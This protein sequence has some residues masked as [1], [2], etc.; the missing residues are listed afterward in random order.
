MR[1]SDVFRDMGINLPE[2]EFDIVGITHDSRQVQPGDLFVALEGE[3]F[4]G[5]KFAVDARARGAVGIVGRGERPDELDGP[6]ISVDDPRQ[7]FGLLASRI[8]EHPDRQ[9]T[10]VGVTGT[11]G[12][13]TI[14]NVLRS[15]L[16]AAG[17]P[18]ASL[19]TLGYRFGDDHVPG[20][21]TTPEAG[22][23]CS[24]L[25]RSIGRG[26]EAMV[27]EVSSHALDLHRVNG[28]QFDVA[29]FTNLTRDHLDFHGDLESYFAAKCKLFSQLKSGG[30]SVINVDDTYGRRL[31]E[32]LEESLTYGA[33][34]DVRA[35][36]AELTETGI[37]AEI[38]TPRGALELRTSLLGRYNLENLLAVVAVAEAL[39][40]PQ[41]AIASGIESSPPIT[42]R[43]D[44]I[45]LGQPFPVYIDYAHTHEALAAAL[46]SLAE[47][48][49]RK[50]ALVF[51]CGGN[52]DRGKRQLMGRVAGEGADLAILTNDN[53]R[54][55]DPKA[56]I[57]EV[58]SGLEE[59]GS[60]RYIVVP[61]RREAIGRAIARADGE[62]AV[63][64]AGKGHE[65][66]QIIG[67]QIIPFSDR[68]E[69]V[70]ALEERF[71][72][73]NVG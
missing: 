40:L 19:G 36:R 12:K 51:G 43:M 64:V 11:N 37:V 55:E 41:A 10:M 73:R 2:G 5:R 45:D 52:R 47:F 63:L 34:G 53:P 60:D 58:I 70:R 69:I 30:T 61:D 8:F 39:D 59:S 44:L 65:E 22:D 13:T 68:E 48:S 62:W 15:V 6:W 57:E 24:I 16:E 42:G 26:V 21:R 38:E 29:L 7:S 3:F 49:G 72:R 20:A 50:I 25:R 14:V 31:A 9:L 67:K 54:R 66:E 33:T 28:L 32:Q 17:S 71:G 27:M 23:L 4:D 1:A 56:I 46:R 35:S 18:C